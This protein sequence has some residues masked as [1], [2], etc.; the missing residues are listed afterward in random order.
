MVKRI[1]EIVQKDKICRCCPISTMM[2]MVTLLNLNYHFDNNI[3]FWIFEYPPGVQFTVWENRN[4]TKE[5]VK[6][7]GP[8]ASP[9]T[10]YGLLALG[11]R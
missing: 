3:L 8:S 10:Y 7:L 2:H 9:T 4:P 1:I 11:L 6:N 5:K